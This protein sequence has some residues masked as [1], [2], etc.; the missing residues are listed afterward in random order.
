[1]N[2]LANGQII[3]KTG[4]KNIFIQPA[5]PDNGGALGA[6]YLGNLILN[7]KRAYPFKNSYLGP[8]F[9]DNQI[10]DEFEN[11]KYKIVMET[12]NKFDIKFYDHI[13]NLL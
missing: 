6:A 8:S 12:S 2:T 11:Y 3:S 10:L 5:A 9:T 4:F 7:K 1:M 13:A